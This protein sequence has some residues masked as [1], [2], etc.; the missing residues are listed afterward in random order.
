MIYEIFAMSENGLI[1]NNNAIP[2]RLPADFKYFKETT[3]GY[4]IVMGRKTWES[5]GS[6]PLP[7]RENVVVSSASGDTKIALENQGCS[8]FNSVEAVLEHYVDKDFFVIG[9]GEIY[10]AFLPHTDKL[11]VTIVKGDFEGDVY[12]CNPQLDGWKLVSSVAG[13]VNEKNVYEHKFNI[14]ERK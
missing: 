7:G 4:P 2:W 8:V 3:M 10:R 12:F 14:Y 9:G 11:Y 6:K 1:G 13:V 5:I